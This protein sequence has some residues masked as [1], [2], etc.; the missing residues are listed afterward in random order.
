MSI[1]KSCFQVV[2]FPCSVLFSDEEVEEPSKKKPV[3]EGSSQAAP[4]GDKKVKKRPPAKVYANRSA[5]YA[6]SPQKHRK[7]LADK[8]VIVDDL[9]GNN[10]LKSYVSNGFYYYLVSFTKSPIFSFRLRQ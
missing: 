8:K 4:T 2:F 1:K 10:V 3:D 6:R 5:S 9:Y 7:T